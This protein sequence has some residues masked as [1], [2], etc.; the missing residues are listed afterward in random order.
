MHHADELLYERRPSVDS[1][2]NADL[3]LEAGR[4]I[5]LVFVS[6][7]YGYRGER[8]VGLAQKV[9]G[10]P[11]AQLRKIF[12]RRLTEGSAEALIA[13]RSEILEAISD[14][15]E[16]ISGSA[17]RGGFWRSASRI[18]QMSRIKCRSTSLKVCLMPRR[19]IIERSCFIR[20]GSASLIFPAET[21]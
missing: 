2:R 15:T 11:Y 17:A 12:A 8:K 1:R 19:G 6:A 5:V 20:S 4:E 21:L 18:Y 3:F 14:L 9:L 13:K 10:E 7:L 16:S